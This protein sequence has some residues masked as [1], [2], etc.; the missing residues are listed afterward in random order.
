MSTMTIFIH[1]ADWQLG[2]PFSRV[3]DPD[4]RGDLRRQRLD[5]IDRIGEIARQQ[6][7]GFVVVA[8]DIFD[9]H[10]PPESLISMALAR[11]GTLGLPVYVIPGNHDHG[12]PGCLW[13]SDHFKRE[14]AA[15][16]PD[17]T[18]LLTAEP[19]ERNDCLL[20]PCPLLRRQAAS[21]PTAWIRSLDF[22]A[23]DD[24]PR[25]VLAHGSTVNF[26]SEADE[27][28]EPGQANFI[29]LARLSSQLEELDYIA[30]GDWHGFVQAGDKAWYAG[31]HETDR[32]PK[33]GQKPGHVA[34]VKVRRGHDPLVE[35]IATARVRWFEHAATL[36]D[37]NGPDQL[38]AALART[39][40][41]AGVTNIVARLRLDGQL[42]LEGHGH[43]DCLLR[44]WQA[45]MVHLRIDNRITLAPRDEELAALTTRAEDPLISGVA[46]SLAAE[47]GGQ[48][49]LAEIAA[50]ALTLLY[51]HV[52]Q[53]EPP[54]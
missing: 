32:F 42:G 7:A 48:D 26:Q 40:R 5:T 4:R 15:L 30:L 19:V 17:L 37:E 6:Q 10:R 28:D 16:A 12:G 18:V 52:R 23:F 33:T 50:H 9:S 45:R 1:T 46:R 34:C 47:A 25:V 53:L 35:A 38:D 27:E 31:T 21:D 20:L 41:E 11:I 44:T 8:G 29:D 14:Q 3:D 54:A 36:T 2:K 39:A 49:A 24:R 22:T 43:L 51:Q 13:E